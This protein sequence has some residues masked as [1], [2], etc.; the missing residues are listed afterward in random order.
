MPREEDNDNDNDNDNGYHY[1]YHSSTPGRT[2]SFSMPNMR[3]LEM[4]GSG[5]WLGVETQDLDSDLGDYFSRP[6][7]K[8][9]LVTHVLDDTPAKKAGMRSGDVIIEVDGKSVEDTYDLR[10]DLRDKDAGPV[11]VTVLRK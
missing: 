8:G 2:Y 7:G 9:V 5:P 4:M 6:D 3:E 1:H 11:K 10:I